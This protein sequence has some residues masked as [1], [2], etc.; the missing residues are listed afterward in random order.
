MVN[1]EVVLPEVGNVVEFYAYSRIAEH[2]R[3]Y[4]RTNVEDR[5][6]W[7]PTNTG[8][9]YKT[10][11]FLRLTSE[12]LVALISALRAAGLIDNPYR[13]DLEAAGEALTSERARVD[14]LIDIVQTLVQEDS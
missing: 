2:G 13:R 3:V 5:L 10:K 12:E 4:A 8:C 9:G 7:V 11:P 14:K 6:A 1:V